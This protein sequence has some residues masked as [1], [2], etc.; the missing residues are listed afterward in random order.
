MIMF[1]GKTA[2]AV[3]DVDHRSNEVFVT[4]QDKS[5]MDEPLILWWVK[6]VLLK[7]TDGKHCLLVLVNDAFR[8]HITDSVTRSLHKANVSVVVIP[9][10][11]TSKIQPIDVCLNKP[12]K[13]MVRGEWEAFLLSQVE[14]GGDTDS[15]GAAKSDIAKW[16]L[17][18]NSMLTSQRDLVVKCFKVCGISSAM[19]GSEN[20]LVRCA[21]EMPQFVLPYAANNEDSDIFCSE[22]DDSGSD[23]S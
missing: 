21:K 4:H 1:K 18:T 2:R 9:G 19:N 15:M 10:G 20:H 7:H 6:D 17:A 11:C 8:A 5:W 3:R 12:I 23:T 16:I 14:A 22:S 13:D